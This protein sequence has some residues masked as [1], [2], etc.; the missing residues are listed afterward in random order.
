MILNKEQSEKEFIPQS[1]EVEKTCYY[2]A[3]HT[4]DHMWSGTNASLKVSV[5]GSKGMLGKKGFIGLEE[6]KFLFKDRWS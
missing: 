4:A 1:H 6:Q 5:T 3:T 2:I